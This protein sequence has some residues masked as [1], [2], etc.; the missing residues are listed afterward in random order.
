MPET[1]KNIE[2]TLTGSRALRGLNYIRFLLDYVNIINWFLL[3]AVFVAQR[4][5]ARLDWSG[6]VW[7][8]FRC[9]CW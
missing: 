7:T 5:Q 4:A 8:E 9:H 3:D 1:N 6:G 2:L